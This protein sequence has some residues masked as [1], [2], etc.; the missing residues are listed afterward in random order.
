MSSSSEPSS[1]TGK[2]TKAL[3]PPGQCQ[4]TDTFV[5]VPLLERTKV[6]ETTSVFRFGLPD[7]SKPLNLS[8]C[9]CILAKAHCKTPD[10]DDTTTEDVVRPYTPISTNA[11]VGCFDLLVKNYGEK[12]RM[13]RHLHEMPLGETVEFKHIDFNVKIQAPLFSQKKTIVMLVGGT[14][15][16]PMIQALHA[17]LGDDTDTATA[18]DTATQ[19]IMLYG[20]QN[21]KDILGRQMVDK[22]A[23]EYPDRLKVVHVLSCEHT[24][25]DSTWTGET[26]FIDREKCERYLPPPSMGDDLIIFMCGPPPMNNALCGPRDVKEV[27]GVLGEM[28]YGSEQ[29]FKF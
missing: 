11:M 6:S 7:T 17:I 1:L 25:E 27:T 16:T 20:S 13:S 2:P 8:T 24:V 21:S 29:V 3:V 14:G 15:I 5:A 23:A 12:A 4:F 22:W 19:V 18:T 26:G 9:A 28:G 10:E